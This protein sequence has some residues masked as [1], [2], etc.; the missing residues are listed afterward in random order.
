MPQKYDQ[1]SVGVSGGVS[2][3]GVRPP[4]RLLLLAG[5][6]FSVLVVCCIWQVLILA[7]FVMISYVV[8]IDYKKIERQTNFSG[9]IIRQI[10]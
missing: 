2:T 10:R 6:N 8:L 3:S 1:L 9:Y 7:F 4:L 5:T